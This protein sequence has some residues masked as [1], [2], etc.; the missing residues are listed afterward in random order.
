M[1]GSLQ[2]TWIRNSLLH[3]LR[4]S[5][6]SNTRLVTTNLVY[7]HP[8]I[9]A[10][11]TFASR[12]AIPAGQREDQESANKVQEVLSMVK[13]YSQSF[14]QHHPSVATPSED[15]VMVTG[16]TGGLGA[17][18]LAELVASNDVARVF[19]VNRKDPN[20][21]TLS[22]RQA[23]SLERQGLDPTIA[24]SPKVTLVEAD[25]SA[26]DLGLASDVFES[27]CLKV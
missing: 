3:A 19:A 27:V 11:T 21:A 26:S 16:T 18:L 7:K 22:V 4:S 24:F 1:L 13:I 17:V 8:S 2:A 15:V 12:F 10:L 23:V 6:Q 25:L 20:G 5:T 9:L 14:P